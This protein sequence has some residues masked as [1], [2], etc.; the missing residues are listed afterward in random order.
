MVIFF[1]LWERK[2]SSRSLYF[3]FSVIF[4]DRI[5]LKRKAIFL[6]EASHF[7]NQS[8]V[9]Y[10]GSN[11]LFILEIDLVEYKSL[12]V[13][14]FYNVWPLPPY[15]PTVSV[16]AI[17]FLCFPLMPLC[18]WYTSLSTNNYW[19]V[20]LLLFFSQIGSYLSVSIGKI[21]FPSLITVFINLTLWRYWTG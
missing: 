20:I 2:N 7:V 13:L 21:E 1:F 12:V 5:T 16:P 8:L 19:S 15:V 14:V 3:S 10:S 6:K 11:Y 18:S 17:A 9:S 4:C